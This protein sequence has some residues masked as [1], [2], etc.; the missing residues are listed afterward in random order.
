MIILCVPL[1]TDHK[2]LDMPMPTNPL[3]LNL[4]TAPAVQKAE[5]RKHPAFATAQRR[6]M[7]NLHTIL[8]RYMTDS[9]N[10]KK[11][12]HDTLENTL[13]SMWEDAETAFNHTHYEK[14]KSD[15]PQIMSVI[16][17]NPIAKKDLLE[18]EDIPLPTKDEKPIVF[19]PL[20]ILIQ[21]RDQQ[22][23]VCE[24]YLDKNRTILIFP[25]I[26]NRER[27][28]GVFRCVITNKR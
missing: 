13:E 28:N 26:K 22:R 19:T 9:L 11:V 18:G 4:P 20:S 17:F 27:V 2:S 12:P 16:D 8:I 24:E 3:Q 7:E 5:G 10:E 21:S 15:S 1:S 6:A 14:R 23:L 25:L